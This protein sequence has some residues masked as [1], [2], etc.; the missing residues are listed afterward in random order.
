MQMISRTGLLI[1]LTLLYLSI[2][3]PAFSLG[4]YRDLV[5]DTKGNA[6]GNVTVS[7]YLA[8]TQDLATIYS[9][10]NSTLKA[11]PFTTDATGS[12]DF[13]AA[14][15]L[16]DIALSCSVCYGGRS[17]TFDAARNMNI[18]ILDPGE[19][20]AAGA[21]LQTVVTAGS[22]ANGVDESHP[23]ELLGSGAQAL[24][25]LSIDRTSSGESRWRCKEAAGLNKCHYYR[26]ID[27]TFEGGFKDKNGVKR[28]TVSGSNGEVTNVTLDGEGNGNTITLTEENWFDVVACQ[29]TTA[30]HIWNTITATS[31]AASC[32]TG[33]NTQKGYASFDATT[34]EAIQMDWV[35]PTGF[36]LTIG[37][38]IHFIWKAAATSGAVGWCAQLI[39]VADA[40][41]S[42]PAFPAQSSGNCVSDTAK[43]TTLQE[44]HATIT[45]VTCTSCVAR[46]HVYVRIS[47]DA[48]GGAVTDSMTG[49]AHLMKVG[50]TWRVAH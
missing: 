33:T 2:A 34:D 46:D 14:T 15:A 16:Y 8:G 3:V 19:L 24:Y 10:T 50:R 48:N 1:C 12:Y 43:G 4:H 38:D 35:L 7:V 23:F 25:G 11:N 36:N 47:R 17:Y 27:D 32:D 40:S 9:D 18:S 20:A 45:G 41:T 42:D 37:I 21:T 22:T 49:D 28:L 26:L 44:N 29:D 31:P 30:Q 39:R 5:Q 6:M 13:Y